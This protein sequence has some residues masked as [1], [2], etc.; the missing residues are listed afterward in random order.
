MFKGALGTAERALHRRMCAVVACND[1][2]AHFN[3]GEEPLVMIRVNVWQS[4]SYRRGR[5]MNPL[6]DR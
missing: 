6:V 4:V 5:Q 3:V 1:N 2:P